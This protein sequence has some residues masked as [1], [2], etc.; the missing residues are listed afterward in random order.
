MWPNPAGNWRKSDWKDRA[1]FKII[2]SQSGKQAIAIHILPNIS[3][4]KWNQTMKVAQ[5]IENN[6]RNF[7]S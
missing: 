4:L 3:I 6:L 1:N 2:M 7:F 5:L